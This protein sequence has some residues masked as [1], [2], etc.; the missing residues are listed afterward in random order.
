MTKEEVCKILAIFQANYA[1]TS[2]NNPNAISAAAE[3]WAKVFEDVPYKTAEAAALFH[4]VQ[5]TGAFMPTVGQFRN[6]IARMM[7]ENDGGTLSDGE[8]WTMV[9]R[10]IGNSAYNA[11]EEFKKLPPLVQSAVGSASWLH[12]IAVDPAASMSVIES[13]FR[14]SFRDLK[15]KKKTAVLIPASVKK[16]IAQA[17]GGMA[18][19]CA[20]AD[21]EGVKE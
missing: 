11:G 21:R 1:D 13:N 8:A 5:D 17:T 9:A 20:A 7:L 3:T 6:T 18:A 14:R 10:A 12:Q 16:Y 2:R 4:M 19:L 15:D